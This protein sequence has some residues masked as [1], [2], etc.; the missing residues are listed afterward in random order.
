MDNRDKSKI[1]EE[2][3]DADSG[4]KHR[5][6][7]KVQSVM[8]SK[9]WFIAPTAGSVGKADRFDHFHEKRRTHGKTAAH[10]IG[11]GF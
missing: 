1:P 6:F 5:P 3:R 2:R 4:R 11:L 8:D 10:R 9:R 7:R